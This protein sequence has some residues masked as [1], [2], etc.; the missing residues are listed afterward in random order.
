M[1]IQQEGLAIFDEAV[2][3]LEVGLT[4]AD[5]FDF[6]AAQGD[7]ALEAVE[8]E[9]VV[10]GGAVDGGIALAG[11]DRIARLVFLQG[12]ELTECV[13]WRAIDGSPKFNASTQ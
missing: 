3:V 6:G 13:D 7:S 8:Q 2:G 5:G 11:G 12:P 1:G 9:V 10:A 4:F